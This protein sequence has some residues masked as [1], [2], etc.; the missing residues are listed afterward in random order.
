[1]S[2]IIEIKSNVTGAVVKFRRKTPEE[3]EKQE[4]IK[5]EQITPGV[6]VP[7]PNTD[8]S[9]AQRGNL[10]G[11]IAQNIQSPNLVR[12]AMGGL[13]A[14]GAPFTLL[15]AGIANPALE[16][17]KGNFNPKDLLRE[18]MAGVSGKKLGRYIDVFRRAGVP[19][20]IASTLDIVLSTSPIKALQMAK[21]A[22][23]PISKLSDKG[24]IQAGD[25]LIK[26]SNEA[27][28]FAG[29]K[30]GEAFKSVD[31]IKINTPAVKSIISKLPKALQD[32]ITE[33]IGKTEGITDLS[34]KQVRQI[35]QIVG[36]YK[37]KM[38]G[39]EARGVAENIEAEE[40]NKAYSGLKQ[41]MTNVIKKSTDKKTAENLLRM[42][43]DY[44]EV[45]NAADYIRK[46]IVDAT[47]KKPT[48]AGFMAR[49]MIMPQDVSGREA[50]NVLRGSGKL[51]RKSINKSL[52]NM[53]TFNRWLMLHRLGEHALNAAMF[54]GI[55]GGIGGLLLKK[56][57]GDTND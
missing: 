16:M 14:M 20:P 1:M 31:N 21:R 9:I 53:E 43:N 44:S 42:E 22:I 26:A 52:S 23:A 8:L 5:S 36:K 10:F 41:V 18:S 46:T 28:K 32:K 17:Q 6:N 35:K 11:N 50:L 13:E 25:S 38:W 45:S 47:L 4:V 40:M 15:A 7:K 56:A 49:K 37:P 33:T 34:I 51:A 19:A 12:K 2:D 27:E 39:Q 3:L 29:Q 54:G 30:L 24:I 48:K 55:A 57:T